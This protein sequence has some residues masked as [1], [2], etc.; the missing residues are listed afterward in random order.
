MLLLGRL[1]CPAGDTNNVPTFSSI[2]L[3]SPRVVTGTFYEIGSNRQKVLFTFRR[4]ATRTGDQIQVEE[5]FTLPDDAVACREHIH[6]L[7]GRLLSYDSEDFRAD[8]RGSIVVD[9]DPKNPKKERVRLE[10]IQGRNP[11]ARVV[12]GVE[13]LQ[14]N[15]LISDTIYPFILEHWEDVMRGAAVKFR[16]VSLEP[17]STFGFKVVKEA[18]TTASGRPTVR[19]KMEPSNLVVAQLIR[20]IYFTIEKTAPH[21]VFSYVGRITPREKVGGAWKFVDAEAVIDWPS[22]GTNAPP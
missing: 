18:E 1:V 21:R 20:P 19:I 5:T 22:G 9:A 12:K 11:G 3:A 14:T 17:A 8:I 6:Y 10:Q 15:T 2:D 4:T 16:L 7:A 13:L